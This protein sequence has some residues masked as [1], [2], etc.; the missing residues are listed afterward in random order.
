MRETSLRAL[1][2]LADVSRETLER[3]ADFVQLLL[4]WNAKI[5]LVASSTEDDVWDR[6][7][8]DSAQVFVH[9]MAGAGHWLDL[10]AGGGFPGLVV[11]I[12]AKQMA[13]DLLVELVESDQRK[14]AFLLVASQ[15]LHLNTRIT[16]ARIEDLPRRSADVVSARA[17]AALPQLL[18]LAHPH[19]APDGICV[20]LKGAAA[21]KEIA[22]ARLRYQFELSR[23]TSVTDRSGVVLCL[24]GVTRV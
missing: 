8:R 5:N 11:A 22:D 1:P 12:L 18:D 7:V 24:K 20:F 3:L 15:T 10:G 13:P 19:L 9:A 17:L 4:K 16:S 14:G 21:D 6:H 2:G 23:E